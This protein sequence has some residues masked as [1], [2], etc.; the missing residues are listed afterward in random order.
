MSLT[1]ILKCALQ[2]GGGR[3]GHRQGA[4]CLA[5]VCL[6]AGL[7]VGPGSG[8]STASERAV[9]SVQGSTTFNSRILQPN[10]AEIEKRSGVHL[11]VVPNKSIWGLIALFE[12]RADLAMMSA[13]ISSEVMQAKAMAPGLAFD[14]L[15]QFVVARVNVAFITHADN[16]VRSLTHEQLTKILRGEIVNWKDVGGADMAIRVVATQNGGG[17]VMALRAQLLHGGEILAKQPAILESARHVVEAVAQLPG[18]IGVAQ[19]GLASKANVN[20]LDTGKPIAQ[21]LAF[22]TIGEPEPKIRA[23]IE[24]TQTLIDENPL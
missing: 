15:R 4:L 10:L 6:A 9:V 2:G 16:A 1:S 12:K 13:D 7:A 5:T 24:A 19:T 11:D 21:T 23:V 8:A 22:V 18:A 20:I 17:T 14:A 3:G